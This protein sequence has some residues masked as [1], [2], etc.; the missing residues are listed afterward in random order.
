MAA[1]TS[2]SRSLLRALPRASVANYARCLSTST[3]KSVSSAQPTSSFDSP[4]KGVGNSETSKIPDFSHYR[5]KSGSRNNAVFQYFMVGTMGALTA[6]GAKATVQ[7]ALLLLAAR[8]SHQC[9][10]R[11]FRVQSETRNGVDQVAR[12]GGYSWQIR[13]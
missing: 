3:S 11:N 12:I 2:T 4:F 9:R 13:T 8:L 5:S 1:L 7:G 6:A 10:G